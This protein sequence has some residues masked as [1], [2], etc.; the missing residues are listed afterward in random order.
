MTC[1]RCAS[2]AEEQQAF[3]VKFYSFALSVS[4]LLTGRHFRSLSVESATVSKA[5]FTGISRIR[6]V[7]DFLCLAGQS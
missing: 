1:N 4:K 3:A 5:K 6:G 7:D 2:G